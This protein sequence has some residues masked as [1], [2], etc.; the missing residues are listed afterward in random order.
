[1]AFRIATEVMPAERARQQAPSF[2]IPRSNFI[3]STK[4]L[5]T[6]ILRF[7]HLGEGGV[8]QTKRCQV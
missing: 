4:C 2:A 3:L 5:A 1:M 6:A 8:Q 7:S